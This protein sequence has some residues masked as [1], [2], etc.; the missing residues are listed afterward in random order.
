MLS[1][2][3]GRIGP[4]P[5]GQRSQRSASQEGGEQSGHDDSLRP[6]HGTPQRVMVGPQPVQPATAT[7]AWPMPATG[8]LVVLGWSAAAAAVIARGFRWEPGPLQRRARR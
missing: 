4:L 2:E 5:G 7:H 6:I 1:A 3:A 8:L